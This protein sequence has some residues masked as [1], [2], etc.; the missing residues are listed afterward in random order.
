[1]SQEI[2]E[3]EEMVADFLVDDFTFI[4]SLPIVTATTWCLC[5]LTWDFISWIFKGKQ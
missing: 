3:K 5:Y 4:V 2:H 1:M